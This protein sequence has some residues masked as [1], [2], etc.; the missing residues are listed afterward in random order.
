MSDVA[1][2]FTALQESAMKLH[3]LFLAYMAAGFNRMEAFELTRSVLMSG[4][5]GE[6]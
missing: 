6:K 1:E 5:R 4:M 3:E 2:P